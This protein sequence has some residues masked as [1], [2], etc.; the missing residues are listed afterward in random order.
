VR[1][2]AAKVTVRAAR[3][4]DVDALVMLRLANARAHVALDPDSYRVP[5]DAAVRRYF[6]DETTRAGVLVA[7]AG[8]RVVGMVEILPSPEPP[9]HQI[10][11]PRVSAQIHTVVAED[12][13]GHGTG[14]ALLEAAGRW[15][16]E[17]GVAYLS[18]GIHHANAGA[19]RFYARHGFTGSGISLTRPTG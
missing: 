4:A 1:V 8:G 7:E 11:R 10:L 14:G 9:E 5:E 13:R 19:V 2:A 18:A 16:A 3:A 6:S 12:T 17:H 15:A